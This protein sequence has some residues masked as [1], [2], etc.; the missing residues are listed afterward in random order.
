MISLPLVI[1]SFIEQ[2]SLLLKFGAV[3]LVAASIWGHGYYTAYQYWDNWYDQEKSRQITI[4]KQAQERGEQKAKELIEEEKKDEAILQQNEKESAT[5]P[6][7][8]RP[9]LSRSSVQRLNRL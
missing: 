4:N 5:D 7:R 1:K 9:A 6:N 3:A 2:Y 8:D